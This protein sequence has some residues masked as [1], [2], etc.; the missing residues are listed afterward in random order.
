MPKWKKFTVK[1]LDSWFMSGLMTIITIYALFFDDIRIL[2]IPKSVD[3]VFYAITSVALV[4]FLVEII[5]ASLSKS[6]YFN[7]FFFWLD[8]V[9]TVSLI[10]DI[11]WI[12]D[13]ILSGTSSLLSLAKTSRAGRITRV[14]RVIRLIRLIRI[15]KLYKQ[16]KLA[17]QRKQAAKEAELEQQMQRANAD[18]QATIRRRSTFVVSQISQEDGSESLSSLHS[19]MSPNG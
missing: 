11:G 12:M 10:F 2:I 14:I 7:S 17:E 3:D 6:G 13:I 15:V 9:S 18:M 5:L 4:L 16:A 8:L 19:S 1:F